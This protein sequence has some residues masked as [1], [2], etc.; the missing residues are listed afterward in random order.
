[1][2]Y[3]LG[4]DTGG[5]LGSIALAKDGVAGVAVSLPAGG[6]SSLLA[7]AVE[8]LLSADGVPVL[9]LA[10]V[11]VSEGPGSFTGLRIGLA[12]AKGIAA[13]AGV[14][15]VLVSPHEAAAYAS[16][17]AVPRFATLTPGERGHG[18][19]ALWSGGK[20]AQ[21]LWGPEVVPE[22][23]LMERLREAAKGDVPV[24]AA[25]EK[26]E[27]LILDLGGNLLPIPPLGPAIAEL[28]DRALREGRV[29]DPRTAAPAYGRAPNA[30][31]P[32]R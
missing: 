5:A 28:G 3:I 27:E 10:G 1:M 7:S 25:S 15:L 8:R 26:L 30:R 4:I 29:A 21:L 32:D 6:H 2:R 11:A 24:I 13:G 16:R 9:G 31:K 18:M 22:E 23:S 14:S 20:T 17:S 12:W 19:I